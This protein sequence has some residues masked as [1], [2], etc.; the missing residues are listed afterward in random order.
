MGDKEEGQMGATINNQQEEWIML[1]LCVRVSRKTGK[2]LQKLAKL[3]PFFVEVRTIFVK[4][5]F[6]E[7][8]S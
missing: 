7:N 4:T 6:F 5:D 8:F 2:L 3:G 1:P